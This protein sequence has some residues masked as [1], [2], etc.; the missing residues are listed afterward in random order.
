MC[1]LFLQVAD[2]WG[3]SYMME[4]LTNDVYNEALKVIE[5]VSSH[6]HNCMCMVHSMECMYIRND[7]LRR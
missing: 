7:P 5:E 2:P 3:G 6:P 4:S 1:L